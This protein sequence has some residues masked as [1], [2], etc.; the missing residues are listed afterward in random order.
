[1]NKKAERVMVDVIDLLL[2]QENHVFISQ[3]VVSSFIRTLM[4]CGTDVATNSW[5]NFSQAFAENGFSAMRRI[6]RIV[7]ALDRRRS[8]P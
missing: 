2:M 4:F 5:R 6:G 8:S 3:C 1:M 7:A